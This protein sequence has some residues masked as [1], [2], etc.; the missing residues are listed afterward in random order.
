MAFKG[1]KYNSTASVKGQLISVRQ[2]VSYCMWHPQTEML[3][4]FEWTTMQPTGGLKQLDHRG[5][6]TWAEMAIAF[7]NE[8]GY[9][10]C[11]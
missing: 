11:C 6:V 3:K 5:N 7:L 1:T 4:T 9:N 8:T 10:I 2:E